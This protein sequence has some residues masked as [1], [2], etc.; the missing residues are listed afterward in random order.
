MFA[1]YIHICFEQKKEKTITDTT[2]HEAPLRLL[3]VMALHFPP[4]EG[5]NIFG[6]GVSIA[7][8]LPACSLIHA[9]HSIAM[10]EPHS[11]T[12]TGLDISA[13]I[14]DAQSGSCCS[15]QSEMDFGVIVSVF[16][17]PTSIAGSTA[18]ES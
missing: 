16:G 18:P 12:C 11:M 8:R 1:S 9:Q 13:A 7:R 4:L 14:P 2:P 3:F 17:V 6:L 15:I 10:C 5:R